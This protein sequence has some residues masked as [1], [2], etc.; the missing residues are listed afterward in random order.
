MEQVHTERVSARRRR[1]APGWSNRPVA[2]L[3]RSPLHWALS[4]RLML[5]TVRGRRTGK[6]HTLPVGYVQAPGVVYVLVADYATKSWWRN[7]ED[8]AP[9]ALVV[10]RHVL[11]GRGRVLRRDVDRAEFD[12][13]FELYRARFP[14]LRVSPG[15]VLM[16][17]CAL[18]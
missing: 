2:W 6:F 18:A 17:R 14:S 5:I 13:A 8:E 7:L 12:H 4:A 10:R 3:L 16:V 11:D 15:G 1:T 9:V